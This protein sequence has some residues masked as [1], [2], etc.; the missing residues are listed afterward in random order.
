MG[1]YDSVDRKV[2]NLIAQYL[3]TLTFHCSTLGDP[4]PAPHHH[5]GPVIRRD[6]RT[7][8]KGR[9]NLPNR[10]FGEILADMSLFVQMYLV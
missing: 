10:V 4:L 3:L 6:Q 7:P 1:H 8:D 5:H 9:I 2:E